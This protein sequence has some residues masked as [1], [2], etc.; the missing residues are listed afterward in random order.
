MVAN[1]RRYVQAHTVDGEAT[2]FM[3]TEHLIYERPTT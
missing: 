3:T 2:A 1:M